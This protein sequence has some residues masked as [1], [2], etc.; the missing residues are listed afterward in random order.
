MPDAGLTGVSAEKD[1]KYR[2]KDL[3][4]L[5]TTQFPPSFSTRVDMRRVNLTV[6][7]G[8]VTERVVDALGFEDDI[9][10]EYILDMLE[11]AQF[12]DPR[13]VQI[14]LT[15]FLESH[16]AQFM[17]ELWG[18]LVTAQHSQMGIP[19]Q[20]LEQKKREI[21][22][23]REHDESRARERDEI[24]RGYADADYRRGDRGRGARGGRGGRGGKGVR[25]GPGASHRDSYNQSDNI[26]YTRRSRSRSPSRPAYPAHSRRSP[27]PT[28][29]RD[30]ADSRTPE[31][32]EPYGRDRLPT[33]EY[34]DR[35]THNEGYQ[36]RLSRSPPRRYRSPSPRRESYTRQGSDTPPMR[37]RGGI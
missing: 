20:W 34:R 6:F 7:R 9:V 22:A 21:V 36:T 33:P 17:E 24:R 31:Y 13:H 27:P 3:H 16:T 37:N 15:G 26:K 12:P 25:G 11:A 8:W 5:R 29:R 23:K 4:T 30:R 10:I 14:S 32:R 35:H 18:L 28:P 1:R 2:D 19:P